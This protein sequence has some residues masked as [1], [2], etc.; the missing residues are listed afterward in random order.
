VLPQK[1]QARREKENLLLKTNKPPRKL[2]KKRGRFI[3]LHREI[4]HLLLHLNWKKSLHPPKPQPGGEGSFISLHL[5]QQ[6]RSKSIILLLDHQPS[7]K[8][9]KHKSYPRLQFQGK[10][11][12]RVKELKILLR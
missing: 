3:T 1:E 5:L 11:K 4:F 7:R 2:K 6:L 8:L 12:I 9:L 10:R